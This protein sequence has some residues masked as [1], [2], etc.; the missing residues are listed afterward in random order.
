MW[1]A[2]DDLVGEA[3]VP[4]SL[5]MDQRE[6]TV[7]ATLRAPK[8]WVAGG[9]AAGPLTPSRKWK[10]KEGTSL[11]NEAG[12]LGEIELRLSCSER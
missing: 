1:K 5:L 4:L 11:R 7:V 12:G 2:E 3:T 9:D 10:M 8:P 6:H